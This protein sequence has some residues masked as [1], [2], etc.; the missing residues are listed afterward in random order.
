MD[1]LARAKL[2]E[3]FTTTLSSL[4]YDIGLG[5]RVKDGAKQGS[6]EMSRS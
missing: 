2:S 1:G 4:S 6:E 5:D 3:L